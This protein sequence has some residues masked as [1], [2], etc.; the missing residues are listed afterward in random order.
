MELMTLIDTVTVTIN[1]WGMGERKRERDIKGFDI[2]LILI[3]L[4]LDLGE[5]FVRNFIHNTSPFIFIHTNSQAFTIYFGGVKNNICRFIV[6]NDLY[7]VN[8][9]VLI[10]LLD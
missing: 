9:E 8:Y 4:N 5:V 6:Y 10:D 7:L 2:P 3:E 1:G